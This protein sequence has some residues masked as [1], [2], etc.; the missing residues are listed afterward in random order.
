MPDAMGER[1]DLAG[2]FYTGGTTG[3]S[4]GVML[5]RCNWS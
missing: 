2:I 4:K 5:S 1:G 3:R